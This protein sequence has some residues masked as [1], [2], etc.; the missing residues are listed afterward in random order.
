MHNAKLTSYTEFDPNSLKSKRSLF[1]TDLKPQITHEEITILSGDST[2]EV[3][4]FVQ[5]RLLI[6][7]D[8]DIKKSS[9]VQEVTTVIFQIN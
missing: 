6:S 4:N 7:K 1:S 8:P 5:N 2:G 9:F 3:S